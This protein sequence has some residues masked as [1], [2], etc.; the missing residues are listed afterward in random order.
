MIS[1]HHNYA[2]DSLEKLETEVNHELKKIDDWLKLNR[3]T[4]KHQKTSYIVINKYFRLP[5]RLHLILH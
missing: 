3:L 5:I 1:I 2:C 4:L